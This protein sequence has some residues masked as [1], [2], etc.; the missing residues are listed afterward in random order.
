LGGQH[1]VFALSSSRWELD[2]SHTPLTQTRKNGAYAGRRSVSSELVA[3]QQ[4]RQESNLQPPV[5]ETGALP[6]ELRTYTDLP[7]PEAVQGWLTGI[8][9]AT[10]G[11]TIRC[12][13]QLSYSHHVRVTRPEHFILI[14]Q[15]SG[16]N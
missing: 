13:N 6:I 7:T 11:T 10:P 9:P 16:S 3:V 2:L 12:S 8:E 4:A 5:L 1:R 14:P 15:S